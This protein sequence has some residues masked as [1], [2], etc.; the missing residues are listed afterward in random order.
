MYDVIIIGKGPAGLSAA[1]YT[2]RAN[3]KTLIIA[4]G[5]GAAATTDKIDNYFGFA[6]TVS[7]LQL[8]KDTEILAKSLGG[9]FSEEEVT[10][11]TM[12]Y[13]DMSFKISTSNNSYSAKKVLLAT[14]KNRVLPNIK[15]LKQFDGK[16]VSRCAVC[17]AF[18]YRGKSVAVLGSGSFALAEA[19]ELLP[20]VGSITLYTNGKELESD[21]FTVDKRKIVEAYGDMKIQGFL[22]EDGQKVDFDGLFIAEGTP[23]GTEFGAKLGVMMKDGAVITDQNG[24]TN[25]PGFYAAGDCVGTP[26]QI[27]VAVGQGALAAMAIT[28]EIRNEKNK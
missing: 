27:S 10:D 9:E 19:S 14:G 21:E 5:Y 12:N 16:G 22:M 4:N 8:V 3:L 6:N 1:L 20:V 2:V 24:K 7:G 23:G 11:I 13:D 28:S 25:V 17:D 26:Y 15:G 18:F